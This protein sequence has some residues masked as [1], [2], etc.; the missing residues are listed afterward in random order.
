VLPVARGDPRPGRPRDDRR[1]ASR[2]S[3]RIVDEG[4]ARGVGGFVVIT[5]GF[6]ETSAA[7]R[8]AEERLREKVRAAGARLIGP[9]CMGVINADPAVSLNATFSPTP[10]RGARS[11]SSASPARSAWRS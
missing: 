10:A 6:G 1:A 7:G 9:N 4:I 2:S 11:A 5:A 3:R 8:A